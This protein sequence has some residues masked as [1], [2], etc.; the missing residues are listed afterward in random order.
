MVVAIVRAV[1]WEV[2]NEPEPRSGLGWFISSRIETLT[3]YVALCD[4]SSQDALGT[5]FV[6]E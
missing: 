5:R 3:S 4:P 2:Q 1:F 6:A